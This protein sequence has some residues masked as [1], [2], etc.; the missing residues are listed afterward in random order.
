MCI[1]ENYIRSLQKEEDK[2]I[3]I[4]EQFIEYLKD[5]EKKLKLQD[6]YLEKNSNLEKFPYMQEIKKKV[7]L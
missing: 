2:T 5:Q 1:Y 3:N 4:Y 6:K 7:L